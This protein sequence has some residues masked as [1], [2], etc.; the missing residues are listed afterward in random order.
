MIYCRIICVLFNVHTNNG[1]I[2]IDYEKV[3]LHLKYNSRV[4][5]R[6]LNIS[7]IFYLAIATPL[8]SFHFRQT[9]HI[10]TNN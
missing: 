6:K 8:V 2:I 5:V 4:L 9:I 1:L 10:I 7:A 3:P